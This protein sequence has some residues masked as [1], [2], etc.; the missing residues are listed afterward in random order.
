MTEEKKT[1]NRAAAEEILQRIRGESE[2]KTPPTETV[3]AIIA[4]GFALLAIHDELKR[5]REHETAE[6][7][8]AYK[9]YSGRA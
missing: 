6:D 8:P 1:D 2:S 4:V 9:K 3:G 7:V 5:I